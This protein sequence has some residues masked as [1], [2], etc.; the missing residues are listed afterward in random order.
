VRRN[1]IHSLRS[2][3]ASTRLFEGPISV[4]DYLLV[5]G[6]YQTQEKNVCTFVFI[7]PSNF[8]FYNLQLFLLEINKLSIYSLRI[9]Y[10]YVSLATLDEESTVVEDANDLPLVT[11]EQE[12]AGGI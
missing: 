9:S 6:I 7:D 3:V 4:A 5:Y 1:Y 8:I 2:N 11:G 12:N 10:T